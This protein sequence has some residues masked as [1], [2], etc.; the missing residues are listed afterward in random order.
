[1]LTPSRPAPAHETAATRGLARRV[2]WGLGAMVTLTEI[3]VVGFMLVAA[4]SPLDALYMTVVTPSTV[5]YNEIVPLDQSGRILAIALIIAGISAIGY[6]GAVTVEYLVSG[7]LLA[8]V[9]QRRK[10]QALAALH[11][12][13]IVCGFG[14][15][16]DGIVESLRE[17]GR[18]V[19][20]IEQHAERCARRE[21]P[22]TRRARHDRAA[23]ERAAVRGAG[24]PVSAPA[25]AK[26][27]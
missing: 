20:T 1:M 2:I 8:R 23:P 11:D 7:H 14:R 19:V 16:G 15:V 25:W 18:S 22:R 3:G 13:F 4:A 27:R 17:A 10:E 9:V 6:T 21:D 5:G 26:V 12:H 24:R